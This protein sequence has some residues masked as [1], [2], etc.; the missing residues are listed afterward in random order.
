MFPKQ[1]KRPL[2]IAHRWLALTLAPVFVLILLSGAILAFKPI[3]G[4]STANPSV[5]VSASAVAAALDAIDPAGRADAVSLSADGRSIDL[6]S[7]D[8]AVAGTFDLATRTAAVSQGFDLFGFALGLHKNL[9]VG[10]GLLVEIATYAMVALLIAGLAFGLP[11][12][13]NTIGGWHRG[14]GWLAFPLLALLPV[15]G[16]LMT[17]H[18]GKPALPALA[19]G[20]PIALAQAIKAVPLPADGQIVMARRFRAGSA[21]VKTASSDGE[22]VHVVQSNGQVALAGAPGW[23]DAVHEGTW[24]G[25]WSGALNLVSAL[26]LMGVTVTGLYSWLRRRTQT[27]RRDRVSTER[28]TQASCRTSSCDP[29]LSTFS[30]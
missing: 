12:L 30:Q 27:R 28:R 26:L 3:L 14:M 6:K 25:A 4:D 24:A 16:L 22:Q 9:L 15:T 11:K 20:E 7:K 29:K 19:P 13:R 17:L 18:V 8:P 10:A 2:L 21:M 1:F 23:V 5:R